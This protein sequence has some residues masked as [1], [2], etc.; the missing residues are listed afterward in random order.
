MS[1][2][3][4]CRLATA[5][6][7]QGLRSCAHHGKPGRNNNKGIMYIQAGQQAAQATASTIQLMLL[8]GL[9]T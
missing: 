2:S 8:G 3:P 1:E 6:L 7:I 9:L 5:S 4:N